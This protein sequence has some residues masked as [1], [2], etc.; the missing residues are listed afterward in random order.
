MA[1]RGLIEKDLM[2]AHSNERNE[3]IL[4]ERIK[5]EY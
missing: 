2:S 3:N 4:V 5:H 1:T